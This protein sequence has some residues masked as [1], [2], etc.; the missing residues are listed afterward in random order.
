MQSL[1]GISILA[2]ETWHQ[3]EAAE[4]E[5]DREAI[6]QEI[7]KLQEKQPE[8]I[9]ACAELADQIDLEINTLEFRKNRLIEI[10]EQAIQQLTKLRQNLDD[11][12]LRMNEAGHL[13]LDVVGHNRSISIR[14]NPPTCHILSESEIPA[15]YFSE[16]ARVDRRPMKTAIIKAWKSGIPVSGTA[17]EQKRKVVY[18]LTQNKSKLAKKARHAAT[19]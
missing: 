10:H 7:V 2:A 3:L 1:E 13:E 14:E 16:T 5:A 4:D 15:E 17:V 6:I 8:A 19:D 18:A 12:I 11:S 9:D